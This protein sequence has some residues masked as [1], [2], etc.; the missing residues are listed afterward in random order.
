[1]TLVEAKIQE[2]SL[3]ARL[4]V[5]ECGLRWALFGVLKCTPS[6]HARAKTYYDSIIP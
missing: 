6:R 1:M 4:K 5:A 2:G 3:G